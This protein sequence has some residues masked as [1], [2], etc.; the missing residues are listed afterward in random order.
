M[1][2]LTQW[3]KNV[4]T[5]TQGSCSSQFMVHTSPLIIRGILVFA[6][7]HATTC[8]T[9]VITVPQVV[10]LMRAKAKMPRACQ[11]LRAKVEIDFALSR[12]WCLCKLVV[13]ILS[14][15]KTPLCMFASLHILSYPLPL[16][17]S[18]F[19]SPPRLPCFLLLSTFD[20]RYQSGGVYSY[21]TFLLLFLASDTTVVSLTI[22][23]VKFI[24]S[25]RSHH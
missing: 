17:L 16:S 5:H 19:T 13:W 22:V 4:H 9:V 6:L 8:G 14:K 1:A 15:R 2:V 21:N 11:T 23:V 3:P 10:A 24:F 12:V 7:I 25:F 20:N 18:S